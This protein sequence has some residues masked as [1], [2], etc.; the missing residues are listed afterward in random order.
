[1]LYRPNS[2]S[3]NSYYMLKKPDCPPVHTTNP[4]SLYSLC[5]SILSIRWSLVRHSPKYRRYCEEF[6]C[7]RT[8]YRQTT[9]ATH[10]CHPNRPSNH[11]WNE[12]SY[13]N[14]VELIHQMHKLTQHC[15]QRRGRVWATNRQCA[16]FDWQRVVA[17]LTVDS[18]WD[19]HLVHHPP[20][21]YFSHHA[22]AS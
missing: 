21:T 14:W 10:F 2:A 8:A 4:I 12:I 6:R 9:M 13:E 18:K 11:W 5:P 7:V 16:S 19:Q 1:M 3:L 17:C 15:H 20:T 22:M